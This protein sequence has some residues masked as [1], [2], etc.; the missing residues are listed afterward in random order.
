VFVSP[1]GDGGVDGWQPP[2]FDPTKGTVYF[3]SISAGQFWQDDATYKFTRGFLNGGVVRAPGKIDPAAAEGMPAEGYFLLAWDP[4][5]QKQVW[6]Q[7]QRGRRNGGLLA[8]GG[9][10]LFASDAN[11]IVAYDAASGKEVWTFNVHNHA[12]G[13]PISFQVDGEQYVA[14]VVGQGFATIQPGT[15]VNAAEMPNTNRVLVFK[16]GA[17]GALPADKFPEQKLR[18]PPAR[19]GTPEMIKAGSAIYDRH[20]FFCHGGAARGDKSHPDLRYSDI[21]GDA[22]A[23]K[24]VMID[25]ARAEQGMKSFRDVLTPDLAEAIRA[26]VINQANEAA[27][28]AA[29]QPPAPVFNH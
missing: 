15:V 4:V 29:P 9:G 2:A 28:A 8:T 7:P 22:E 3:R 6:R 19:V 14:I 5:A 27:T 24:G 16:L 23:W 11:D 12:L 25:G 18:P 17:K 1:P 21:L 20:C 10:L 26:F 13:A